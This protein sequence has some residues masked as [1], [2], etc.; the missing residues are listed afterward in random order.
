MPDAA[1]AAETLDIDVEELAGRGPFVASDRC[2]RRQRREWAEPLVAQ[3]CDS[4]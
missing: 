1:D 2:A 4:P 3:G